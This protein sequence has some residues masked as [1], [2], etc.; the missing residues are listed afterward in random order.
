MD[1][2]FKNLE[3]PV[4]LVKE[5]G[6]RC[7]IKADIQSKKAFF[8]DMST[9]IEI[10]DI[11]ERNRGS[12]VDR[13]I[14]TDIAVYD[15]VGDGFDMMEPH[16][17]A[18]I[19]PYKKPSCQELKSVRVGDI[20]ATNVVFNSGNNASITCSSNHNSF[21]ELID[22][23]KAVS[24][25]THIVDSVKD[26]QQQVGKPSFKTKYRDFIASIADHVEI[27]QAI[28]PFVPWLYNL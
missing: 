18:S 28:A 20:T 15:N 23:L 9:P 25:P 4:T 26:L 3:K 1:D 10:G 8:T 7:S 27:F 2:F 17:E 11:L 16:M 6:N 13:Y 14:I 5:S 24:A 21:E 12:I 19:S 22:A